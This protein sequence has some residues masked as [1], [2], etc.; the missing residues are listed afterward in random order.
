MRK[1]TAVVALAVI[2]FG[3]GGDWFDAK[4]PD[5]VELL[6]DE[7]VVPEWAD[8]EETIKVTNTVYNWGTAPV[9]VRFN[10]NFYLSADANY[11]LGTDT[12]LGSREIAP[13]PPFPGGGRD[14][15]DTVLT[16]PAKGPLPDGDYYI[17]AYVD[18]E[19]MV[20]EI[21]GGEAD[22][23]TVAG[24]MTIYTPPDGVDIVTKYVSGPAGAEWGDWIQV[25]Y[26]V[27]NRGTQDCAGSFEMSFYLSLDKQW[28][29]DPIDPLLVPAGPV[30]VAGLSAQTEYS[31][32]VLVQ[33]PVSGV[34]SS[35]YIIGVANTGSSPVPEFGVGLMDN[36]Q[37]SDETIYVANLC[38]L[39]VTSVSPSGSPY[40]WGDQISVSVQI[41]EDDGNPSP[42]GRQVRVELWL[43]DDLTLSG[44]DY[45]LTGLST[46]ALAAFES[47]ILNANVTL[48]KQAGWTGTSYYIIAHVDPQDTIPEENE[49][50]NTRSTSLS[51]NDA[52][53]D[54][55]EPNNSRTSAWPLGSAPY[56][57][58]YAYIRPTGD[59]DWYSFSIPP[60]PPNYY[61]IEVYLYPPFDADYD[62]Y[63]YQGTTLIGSSTSFG[64]GATESVVQLW[65]HAAGTYYIEVVGKAGASS[66]STYRLVV[67]IW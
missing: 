22:N 34:D 37:A 28:D 39:R 19:G 14:T 33:V 12:L 32:T 27:R 52:P 55:Y 21:E 43:S 50:N 17:I 61:Y 20:D 66:N 11:D 4:H 65:G 46:S 42:P 36:D 9:T 48:T 67:D 57:T 35:Y 64:N 7:L 15:D 47:R 53:T 30:T 8:W 3:C 51:I 6:I 44:D 10:V 45:L 29:G 62:L 2:F 41:Y 54:T 25:S 26:T 16:L 56:T 58:R 23:I 59:Q 63:V 13:P 38:D 18:E 40:Y 49:G 60:S 5:G 31:D 24:P 1:S